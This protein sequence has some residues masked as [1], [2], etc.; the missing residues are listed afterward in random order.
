[1]TGVE[2][3]ML[4]IGSVFMIGSFFITERLSPSE[5]NKIA[6][7]SEDELK[8]IIN[9][10]LENAGTRIENTI[11]EQ[12][13][14]SADKVDRALEKETNDKIMAISEYSDTV[15][16]SMNK[17]HNE[18]MFLYSM[19]NDKHAELTGMVS[20]IQKLAAD[21]RNLQENM[22][23]I[24]APATPTAPTASLGHSVP[25]VQNVSPVQTPAKRQP[26]SAVK[27]ETVKPAAVPKPASV[28]EEKAEPEKQAKMDNSNKEI[29]A[30]HKEGVKDVEIARRL[31]L[32]IGEVRLV[33]GLYRGE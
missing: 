24:P 2:L 26:V 7:L 5:L 20:N 16:E 23:A 12:I 8:K 19:L 30:L 6:E 25:P 3:I 9:R 13:E 28:K 11:D 18:I 21:V 14:A 29:L 27:T 32:G 22:P 4:L 31:G 17:T 10:G 1:M 33:I 15:V